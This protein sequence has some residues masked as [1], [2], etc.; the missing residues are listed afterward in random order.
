MFPLCHS[1]DKLVYRWRGMLEV[2]HRLLHNI[3]HGL[4]ISLMI[5]APSYMATQP[6]GFPKINNQTT[7]TRAHNPIQKD[8]ESSKITEE[9][10]DRQHGK[11]KNLT[12]EI[13]TRTLDEARESF[14]RTSKPLTPSLTSEINELPDIEKASILALESSPQEPRQ[15]PMISRSLSS[16]PA[17]P[18]AQSNMEYEHGGKLPIQE[19]ILIC[20]I[21][22]GEGADTLKME[23]SCKGE[24]ALAHKECAV[25][26][27]SMKGNRTCDVCKQ[28]VQNLPVTLLRVHG[29][30]ELNL[31]WSRSQQYRQGKPLLFFSVLF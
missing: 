16:L 17:T 2:P 26:W 29:A 4:N 12:L 27:F 22:L 24:L 13:P 18:I 23:C 31:T 25:K 20:L 21:E 3:S 10:F 7:I 5:D 14:L 1:I 9:L 8:K 30:Q 19:H 15:K 6:Q 28:E 11:R